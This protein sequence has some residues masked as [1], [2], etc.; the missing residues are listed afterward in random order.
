MKMAAYKSLLSALLAFIWLAS[1]TSQESKDS[2][3]FYLEIAAKNNP[4]VVQKMN[5]YQAA[6]QKI[7]QV[8]SLPDPELNLGV[9]LSPMELVGGNQLADI[10]LM[11]MFPWF[12]VLRNAKDEMSLMA[13]A[14]YESFRDTKLQVLYDVQRRWYELQKNLQNIRISEKNIAILITIE[15]ISLVKFKSASSDVS[16]TSSVGPNMSGSAAQNSTTG[17]A[18]MNSMGNNSGNSAS[19][20]GNNQSSVQNNTMGSPAGNAGLADLYRIQIEIGELENSIALL[21]N[22]QNTLTARF[23]AFLNRPP[24]TPIF[25]PDT[26]SADSLGMSSVMITDSILTNNPMLAML[27]YEEQSY[28]ARGKMVTRMG[29]PMV[30]LGVNYSLINKNTMSTSSMNGKDMIMPMITVTLPIYRKKYAAMQRETGLLKSATVAGYQA[31]ANSLQT[32]Y[33]EANQ[34]YQDAARRMKLYKNQSELA[35][36]SLNLMIRSFSVSGSGLTDVLRVRQQTLDYEFKQTEAIADFNISI[37]WLKRLMAVS[38][39]Q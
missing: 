31:S 3:I 7:P 24:E 29:Y 9:F 25:L 13:S 35:N 1:G 17:T 21:M 11:Q 18:G 4:G 32:E 22:Q 8:G 5:E 34:L 19:T 16:S 37:A 28:D 10:R 39:I 38:Q 6:L 20:P 26:I 30:G 2:L 14:R 23:N 12:G 27:K 36:K 33:Y 15:R